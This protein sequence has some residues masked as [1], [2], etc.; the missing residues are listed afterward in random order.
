MS[1]LYHYQYMKKMIWAAE[2]LIMAL[3]IS[4]RKFS[5]WCLLIQ[6]CVFLEMLACDWLSICA[7]GELT[8]QRA[9]PGYKEQV[10]EGKAAVSPQQSEGEHWQDGAAAPLSHCRYFVNTSNFTWPTSVQYQ[11]QMS[12]NLVKK[13]QHQESNL[14][15]T[16][17]G[18]VSF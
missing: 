12:V 1:T 2:I 8:N 9:A 15:N 3:I 6:S 7:R 5:G 16:V 18:W 10:Y 13:I 11:T 17:R 4:S 14:V